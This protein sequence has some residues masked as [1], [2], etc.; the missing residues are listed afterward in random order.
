M[1]SR[2]CQQGQA[3]I[4]LLLLVGLGVVALVYG[5][6]TPARESIAA[7]KKTAAALAQA[8]AALIG[9][10][11]SVD[12][13]QACG[14]G[15]NCPR[16]GDLLCPDTDNDGSAEGGC[17]DAAGSNQAQ[18][19]GRLPWRTL[20]LP[21]LRDGS[22]ERLW[23][24]VSNNFKNNT[25]TDCSSPGLVGCRNSD[26]RGLI[27][28]RDANGTVLNNGANPDAFTPS[29]VIAV[30]IAPGAVL[31]RQDAGGAA[32]N[33]GGA[34]VNVASNYLDIV[35]G[36]EDNANFVD[37]SAT[38][39][40]IHGEV[41]DGGGN[42]IVN[43][44][45]IAITYADLMPLMER[46]VAKEVL[47]CLNA[48]AAVP[49]NRGRYP[50]AAPITDTTPPYADQS[51]TRFGRI[52]DT[53]SS[54]L[55]GIGG[56]I[57][58]AV[59]GLPLVGPLLCMT[60]SFPA[61][62]SFSQGSWWN[63]WKDMVFYGVAQPYQPGDP[64]GTVLFPTPISPGGP[65]AGNCLTVDPPSATADKRVVVIVAGKRLAAVAG[66]QP[67]TSGANKSDATNYVEGQN[68]GGA[69]QNIYTRQT[70]STTFNDY[71]IF[72]Q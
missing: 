63:N 37:G 50:W 45:L 71:V 28:V 69:T 64:L 1:P 46:R 23:Y 59:C 9:Y 60:T 8:K 34:G 55:L 36:V 67:R 24:A 16:I 29:G 27:T 25:R 43:D 19:L 26:S 15:S 47:N 35:N 21:D 57:A 70:T 11:V 32:Q 12:I 52:P 65:C 7:D 30:I 53:F 14:A 31:Q 33:R 20:G 56:P 38:N 3:A 5:L 44:R 68:D 39:G 58:T 10:A 4:I 17:G 6:A 49:Q 51:N 2:T 62:C 66:G 22:G 54:T 13:S 41:R 42:V 72:Q 48:Y 18:R 61:A 40:F